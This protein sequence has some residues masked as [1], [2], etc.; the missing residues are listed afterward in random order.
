MHLSNNLEYEPIY[1]RGK[2]SIMLTPDNLAHEVRV[3][4]YRYFEG[5]PDFLLLRRHPRAENELGPVRGSVELSE[6]LRDAV[7]REVRE[8][9]GILRPSHL[10]DLEF[11]SKL[12]IGEAGLIQ[13]DFGYQAPGSEAAH[14][15]RKGPQVAEACWLPFEQ[16]FG[17]LSSE[18][19]SALVRLQMMLRAG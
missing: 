16:A 1:R 10:I 11:Q 13:W 9:T 7:L 17:L 2:N 3:F 15:I 18:D 14:G 19:R 12:V 6:H 5:R 8:E 4:V